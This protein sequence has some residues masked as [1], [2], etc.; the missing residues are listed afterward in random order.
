MCQILCKPAECLYG[1]LER[2]KFPFRFLMISRNASYL[3]SI[4]PSLHLFHIYASNHISFSLSMLFSHSCL[5]YD[6]Y[7]CFFYFHSLCF[8]RLIMPFAAIILTNAL[9]WFLFI[10]FFSTFLLFVLARRDA[11]RTEW[12]KIAL[13]ADQL[14]EKN[15]W[16][17]KTCIV[18]LALWRRNKLFSNTSIS[19]EEDYFLP[20]LMQ[21]IGFF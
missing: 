15:E 14:P 19:K 20:F 2:W 11:W 13:K 12:F 18:F 10:Y 21:I 17:R 4:S 8:S 3:S 16:V 7:F 9:A 6:I 5:L 1:L